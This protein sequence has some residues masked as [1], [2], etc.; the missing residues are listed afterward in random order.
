MSKD[1]ILTQPIGLFYNE[2]RASSLVK[3]RMDGTIVNP[4]ASDLRI[5]EVTKIEIV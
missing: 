1:E 4:S 2:I 3:V 5:N